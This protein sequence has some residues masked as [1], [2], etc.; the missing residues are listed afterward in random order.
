MQTMFLKFLPNS[1]AAIAANPAADII[2]AAETWDC[3]WESV[4]PLEDEWFWWE[5]DDPTEILGWN[6]INL[7][8]NKCI[9]DVFIFEN[10]KQSTV[11][12]F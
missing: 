4:E 3:C 11:F 10:I 1:A 5:W 6:W 7:L 8:K 9:V 2:S 12:P